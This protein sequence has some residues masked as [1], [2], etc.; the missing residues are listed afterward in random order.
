MLAA[1]KGH[2]SVLQ[3]LLADKRTLVNLAS[4]AGNTALLEAAKKRNPSRVTMGEVVCALVNSGRGVDVNVK[5]KDGDVSQA[6]GL[7]LLLLPAL[8]VSSP[9]FQLEKLLLAASLG[10][11]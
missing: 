7:G 3:L 6:E 2:L 8:I 5:N 4:E 11:S 10:V 9:Q 1:Y